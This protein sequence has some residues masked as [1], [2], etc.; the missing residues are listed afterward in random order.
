MSADT[1]SYGL[2]AVLTQKQ[3][4]GIWRP[5]AYCSRSMSATEQH[6]A[7]I[8]KEALTFTWACNRF[9]DYLLGKQFHFETDHKPLVSLL[10]SKNLDEFPIRIQK[11]RMR[12]MRYSYSISH[13]PGK[14]LTTA[15]TLSQ[16]PM[17]NSSDHTD[18]TNEVDA[19]VDLVIQY[20]PAT[21]TK[22]QAIREAQA[23]DEVC[24]KLFDYCKHGWPHV[25]NLSVLLRPYHSD[26]SQL[27]VHDG[28][29]LN[30]T[31][32]VIPSALRLDILDQLHRGHQGIT[33]CRARAQQSAWWP[34]LGIQ[35]QDLVQNCSK[36][37]HLH[38]KPP[39]PLIT[40]EFLMEKGCH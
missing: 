17:R 4:D 5:I 40:T 16:A 38:H 27:T 25:H 6:Y 22:L 7:Q 29:L 30:G 13:V 24:Q 39:E 15:D 35:L 11:F 28:L 12:L 20:I 10:G 31:R 26:A 32:I 36:C 3:P 21:A 33:K 2:G 1:S 18:F 9:S 37:R 34:G 23:S 8:E 14:Q 19:Y